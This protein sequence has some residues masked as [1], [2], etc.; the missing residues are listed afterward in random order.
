[1]WVWIPRYKYAIPA[2]TGTLER[3]INIIFE[4]KTTDKS[5][6]N[7]ID[8][9]YRTHPAFT[10][11]TTEVS[12]IWIGKFETT[13]NE[14]T[15]TI[16]PNVTSLKGKN[17]STQFMTA[18]KFSNITVYGF[19]NDGDIHMAKDSEWGAVSYLSHSKYG[20]NEEI[21]INP[22]A[23]FITGRGGNTVSQVSTPDGLGIASSNLYSYD[24]KE[25]STK[26]EYECTGPA[27]SVYGMT[28]ST[29]GNIYG[30]YDISGGAWENTMSMYRPTDTTPVTDNSGFGA[31][32]TIGNLPTNEYWDRYTTSSTITACNEGICYGSALSETKGWYHDTYHFVSA[33]YP[34]SVRG[35]SQD[36]DT[37]AGGFFYNYGTGIDLNQV[38]F[39]VVQM[40]P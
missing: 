29:T 16:K 11:G 35:G 3:S 26:I 24:G 21:Y 31:T 33:S 20:I 40:K 2:N 6:G 23:S 39:R 12:G 10:F 17:V 13:G 9:N 5:P 22:S 1:M 14:T 15:P 30:V 7:A 27:Q 34:W 8:T 28:S 36:R 18:Q 25:C 37:G 4:S 38:S 32:T 19:G